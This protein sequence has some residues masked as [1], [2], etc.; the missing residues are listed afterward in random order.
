MYTLP[1]A[2]AS[3]ST[4]I[5][6]GLHT[7]TPSPPAP[8]APQAASH[9]SSLPRNP[10]FPSPP[11]EPLTEAS[12]VSKTNNDEAVNE[13]FGTYMALAP[14]APRDAA[15]LSKRARGKL[16]R[17]GVSA[18]AESK[19][20][21]LR[22]SPASPPCP[23][24]END[25]DDDDN[26]DD[27]DDDEDDDTQ[28]FDEY[29]PDMPLTLHDA[30]VL[31]AAEAREARAR[32][33]RRAGAGVD[34]ACELR[35]LSASSEAYGWEPGDCG[36][37]PR[38]VKLCVETERVHGT[39]T[40][41]AVTGVE[42]DGLVGVRNACDGLFGVRGAKDGE[43]RAGALASADSLVL[44]VRKRGVEDGRT[45][46]TGRGC[47]CERHQGSDEGYMSGS[48]VPEMEEEEGEKKSEAIGIEKSSV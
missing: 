27:D 38:V 13:W 40:A 23:A 1:P 7:P 11:I 34:S 18:S 15:M 42:S 4:P 41:V 5:H 26:D 12:P 31:V 24:P 45:G 8:S 48:D 6:D 3:S 32:R 44:G 28:R 47:G 46:D 29:I 14:M 30:R 37:F 43:R 17:Q 35:M 39:N 16:V 2:T 21:G 33:A 19:L 36:F 22:R 10:Q 20:P 9:I 25:D